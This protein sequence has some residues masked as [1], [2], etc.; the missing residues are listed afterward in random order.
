MYLQPE[1]ETT[2]IPDSRRGLYPR[3][4]VN[5]HRPDGRVLPVKVYLLNGINDSIPS[6]TGALV[7][8]FRDL[9]Y[10]VQHLYRGT[11]RFWDSWFKKYL[12][13]T[14]KRLILQMGL[15]TNERRAI[16]AHSQGCLQTWFM[17]QEWKR[18]CPEE[19]LFHYIV[20]V[21]PA[22][23]RSGWAWEEQRFERMLVDYNPDDLAIWLGAGL[24]GHLFGWAGC[25]GF[26][27]DDPRIEQR[28][29]STVSDGL[30]GHNH[31]FHNG[32]ARDTVD[33]ID[34]WICRAV[35]VEEDR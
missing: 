8:H 4:S 31:Y 29:D 23:N 3:A 30:L 21:S 25:Q 10:D 24:P 12:R 6:T 28:A 33:M 11:T 35:P 32:T 17:L 5:S 15:F 27:T 14:A 9:E 22:M 18:Y 26:R 2:E 34:R 20:F 1:Q 7:P 13:K 16:V 19:P